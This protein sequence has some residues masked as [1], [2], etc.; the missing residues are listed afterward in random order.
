M[1]I[2]G[3]TLLPGGELRLALV[4]L[5]DGR[6]D[7]VAPAVTEPEERAIRRTPG[8]VHMHT[9]E[10][11]A[12]AYIDVHCHGAGGGAADGG[13]EGL[14]RMAA[15]LLAHGVVGFLATFQTAPLP[16]L[17][18]AALAVAEQMADPAAT[19]A[20]V[21]GV[22]L[23]G[24]AVSR[25]RSAGHDPTALIDPTALGAALFSD[26]AGWRAVRLVTLAPELRGGL[27]LVRR[28][29]GAGVSVS[30]GHTDASAE[31]ASAAYAAGARSTTHL[32]NGMPPLYHRAPGPVGAALAHAPFIELIA[33]GVHVDSRLLAPFARAI[34]A[35][36][37]VFVTDALPLAGSRLRRVLIPG[38]VVVVRNGIAVLPDGGIAGGRLLLDGVVQSAVRA[39]IPLSDALRGAS[40]N[41]ARLLALVDRGV[42]RVGARA[43]LVVV[44][45]EGRLRRV[46]VAGA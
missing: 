15:T 25:E 17:R 10:V 21:L 1:R 16:A 31:V 30:V 12:P 29:V 11:L 39:G 36:R 9:D 41:P 2:V 42:V 35:D 43:D 19:G 37:L 40:E 22:H 45:R 28:L 8:A 46:I 6:I 24:P 3:R 13:L 5:R 18:T 27:E 7:V 33:D 32:F 14:A 23:E 38:S 26:S 20:T 4:S 34:G 44:S